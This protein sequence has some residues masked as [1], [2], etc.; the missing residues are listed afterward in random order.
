MSQKLPTYKFQW[1]EDTSQFNKVFIKNYGEKCE[2]GYIHEVGVQYP[3]KLF[4]FNSHLPILLQRKKLE[5]F[6]NVFTSL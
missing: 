5:R 3:E 1:D 2:V 4:E 6:I